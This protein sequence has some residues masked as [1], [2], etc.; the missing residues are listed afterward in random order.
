MIFTSLTK[1][2]QQ[3]KEYYIGLDYQEFLQALLRE[4]VKHKTFFNKI[5]E[6]IKD[7]RLS[8]ADVS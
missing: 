3:T 4:A 6:K 5:S 2:K 8:N 7:G 1:M